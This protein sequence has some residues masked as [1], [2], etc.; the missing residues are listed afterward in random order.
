MLGR[1]QGIVVRNV[2]APVSVSMY[3]GD[4]WKGRILK[5]LPRTSDTLESP[6][7]VRQK[8]SYHHFPT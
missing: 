4:Q 2:D 7:L 8:S 5:T 3:N 1:E 6:S